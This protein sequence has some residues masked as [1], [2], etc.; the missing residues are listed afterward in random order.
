MWSGTSDLTNLQTK[1]T[2]FSKQKLHNFDYNSIFI[3]PRT[4]GQQLL[5][6]PAIRTHF[7][8]YIKKKFFYHQKTRNFLFLICDQLQQNFMILLIKFMI[9]SRRRPFFWLKVKRQENR[10]TQNNKMLLCLEH[11]SQ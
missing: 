1:N 4:K 3:Q 2:F 7:N 10:S 11:H 5:H 8:V 6:H 9:Q